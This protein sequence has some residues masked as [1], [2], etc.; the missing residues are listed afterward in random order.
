MRQFEGLRGCG[1]VG[2]CMW[3]VWVGCETGSVRLCVRG[4]GGVTQVAGVTGWESTCDGV[5]GCAEL[6]GDVSAMWNKDRVW[7]TLGEI[8]F[9]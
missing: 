7:D 4:W 8:V 5:T 1:T 2:P 6:T 3:S 9:S